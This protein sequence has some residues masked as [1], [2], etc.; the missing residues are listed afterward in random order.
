[1]DAISCPFCNS[2]LLQDELHHIDGKVRCPRCGEP[3][4]SGLTE[5][6]AS[7]TVDRPAGRPPTAPWTNRSIGFA[8]LGVM[9]LMAVAG[10]TL[11]LLTVDARRKNDYRVKKSTAPPPAVEAPGE[12]AGLG[13]L[14]QEVNIVAAM[15]VAELLRDPEGKKLL[16]EPRPGFFDLI[17]VAVQKW[18]ALKAEDIDQIV[19]GT[20]LKDKLPQLTAIVKTRK[21][22]DP[23]ALAKAL[24]P[25]EPTQHRGQALF[26]FAAQPGECMLWC[27]EPRTLVLLF[28]LD[29][30]N[31]ADLEAIP[32]SPRTGIDAVPSAVKNIVEQRISKQSLIWIAGDLSHVDALKEL[33]PLVP[34]SA[35]LA[36]F[37]TKVNAVG[38]SLISQDG[39]VFLGN[40]E[41]A[42]ANMAQTQKEIEALSMPAIK[43]KLVM[44]TSETNRENARWLTVQLRGTAHAFRDALSTWGRSH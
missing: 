44:P 27:P 20:E 39:L 25:I 13:F 9:A 36:Q 26:R 15:Q 5:R 11:A 33:L 34:I 28:R 31:V 18:S 21:P 40:F 38:V 24:A 37:L 7:V 17:F 8:V 42:S 6:V 19:V 35:G 4:P 30:L 14:P 29:A 10:L 41:T 23:A 43:T 12:L 22:Y 2:I 16:A 1:M 3:L 32:L